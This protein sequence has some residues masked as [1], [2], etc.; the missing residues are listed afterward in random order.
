MANENEVDEQI[1]A[2]NEKITEAIKQVAARKSPKS[3]GIGKLLKD[4]KDLNEEEYKKRV[5]EYK[6]IWE[7]YDDW[8]NDTIEG[9]K[10]LAS[11]QEAK[12]KLTNKIIGSLSAIRGEGDT[13]GAKTREAKSKQPKVKTAKVPKI[14]KE[15]GKRDHHE[16]KFMGESF[17]KGKLVL[18][19]IKQHVKKNPKLNVAQLKAAFPEHLL[20]GYGIVQEHARALEVSK[21]SNRFFL[22]E[23]HLVKVQGGVVAVCNQFS[24][25]NIHPFLEH[26]KKLGYE[27]E[28]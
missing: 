11:K 24:V 4:L 7:D 25:D 28:G 16:Y 21:D 5:A 17:K 6:P 19:V 27:I 9:R 18:A 12:E 23:E 2:L 10:V 14:A 8:F 15:K 1:A 13:R 22:K 20:K 3:T 26:A